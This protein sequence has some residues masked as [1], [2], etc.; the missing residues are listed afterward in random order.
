VVCGAEA[1]LLA[2][3]RELEIRG[4]ATALPSCAAEGQVAQLRNDTT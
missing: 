2:L 1:R 4:R 3:P